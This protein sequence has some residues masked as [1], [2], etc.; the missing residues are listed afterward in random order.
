LDEPTSSLDPSARHTV[1]E[2]INEFKGQR[3]FMLCT[4]MLSE[5]E[6]LCDTISIMV[7]GNIYTV[8]SP[9]YLSSKFGTEFKVEIMLTDDQK[10]SK[11]QA[12][13]FF[14]A[15]LPSAKLTIMR[16]R[17][18]IY[19]I[20]ADSTTLPQ[21]FAV[22]GE[23]RT[24]NGGFSYYACASSSLERVFLEIVKLSE[25]EENVVANL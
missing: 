4:H 12:D 17:A 23:G 11:E 10:T 14:R 1:H 15:R 5:A 13:H 24:I 21:L 18:R 16:T 9:Q 19:S 7:K 20:P 2:L 25:E 3:T 8:G 6:A 22:M